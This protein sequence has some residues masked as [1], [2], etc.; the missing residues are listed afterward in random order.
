MAVDA[1]VDWTNMTNPFG[2]G[3]KKPDR[4]AV[5]RDMRMGLRVAAATRPGAPA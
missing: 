2:G 4:K 1:L 3:E 5:A